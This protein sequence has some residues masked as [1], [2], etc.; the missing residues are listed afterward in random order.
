M[1]T[2]FW[3]YFDVAF[4]L[5][6]TLLAAVLFIRENKKEDEA[7]RKESKPTN[8]YGQIV[9]DN[10]KA[11]TRIA[12]ILTKMTKDENHDTEKTKKDSQA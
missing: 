1:S 10:T 3:A 12:D 2:V 9:E 4:V 7:S 5:A 11:L 6:V 8:G